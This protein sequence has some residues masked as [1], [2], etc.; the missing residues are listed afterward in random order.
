[1]HNKNSVEGIYEF[2]KAKYNKIP[3]IGELNTTG[4]RK[5]KIKEFYQAYRST[6]Q[7]LRQAEHYDEIERELFMESVNYKSLALFL[8][9]T[10]DMYIMII[11]I[12]V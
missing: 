1:M 2:F 12:V 9:N 11:G 10:A 8:F 4:I 3:R 5:D 6:A 7:S